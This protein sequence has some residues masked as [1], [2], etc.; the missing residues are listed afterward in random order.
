M[1]SNYPVP[2]ESAIELLL[3]GLLSQ[4]TTVTRGETADPERDAIGVFAEWITDD[5]E[6]AVLGFA[7]HDAV[8][9]TGGAMMSVDAAA[10]EAASGKGSLNSE[11]VEGF[12]E[13]VNVFA[14]Q[15]NSD[16]TK[17]LRLGNVQVL[18]GLLRDEVKQLWRAPRA[19][20]VFR[21]NVAGVGEGALI[22]YLG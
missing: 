14:S 9:F 4:T 13:I 5:G 20:R 22:M 8:N 19:R 10:L 3:G 11:A 15:L 1:P 21:V 18:P 2:S 12:R 17:H 16:F 6:L 7:D